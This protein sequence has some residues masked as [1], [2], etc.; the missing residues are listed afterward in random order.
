MELVWE[1]LEIKV[2]RGNSDGYPCTNRLLACFGGKVR[3]PR[4]DFALL[5]WS[6]QTVFVVGLNSKVLL[7]SDDFAIW[8]KRE[9]ETGVP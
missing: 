3:L 4:S 9:G 8:G 5:Y 7:S 2:P 1:R 6:L